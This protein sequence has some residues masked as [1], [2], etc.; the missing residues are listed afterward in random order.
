MKPGRSNLEKKCDH[1]GQCVVESKYKL[2]NMRT[3][4]KT[5]S[6]IKEAKV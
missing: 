5:F 1:Y 6:R 4:Q 2:T 3:R